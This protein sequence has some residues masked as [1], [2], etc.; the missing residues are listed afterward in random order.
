M[1]TYIF[2]HAFPHKDS[3]DNFSL[4]YSQTP[5]INSS[6]IR[7]SGHLICMFQILLQSFLLSALFLHISIIFRMFTAERQAHAHGINYTHS[8]QNCRIN[9]QMLRELLFAYQMLSILISE[10]HVAVMKPRIKMM[11]WLTLHSNSCRDAKP[12][13]L[14][15]IFR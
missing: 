5:Q 7:P 12:A 4:K 6:S 1:H 13:S 11:N 2:T 15:Y 9:T 14:I 8:P 3:A 10:H